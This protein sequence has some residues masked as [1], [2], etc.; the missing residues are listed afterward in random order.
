LIIVLTIFTFSLKLPEEQAYV[1]EADIV[2][3]EPSSPLFQIK[4]PQLPSS[5]AVSLIPQASTK[6]EDNNQ[7]TTIENDEQSY[8][9]PD[10][11]K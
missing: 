9:I 4:R 8:S 7:S 3:D 5:S 2:I 1:G 11:H 6:S 10:T